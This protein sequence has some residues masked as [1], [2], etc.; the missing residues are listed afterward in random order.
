MIKIIK[1]NRG[2][3]YLIDKNTNEI[4]EKYDP[5]NTDIVL[6]VRLE[7]GSVLNVDS[8]QIHQQV[9]GSIYFDYFEDRYLI[10]DDYQDLLIRSGYIVID[11]YDK[12]FEMDR[13]KGIELRKNIIEKIKGKC[14]NDPIDY[15]VPLDINHGINETKIEF[16]KGGFRYTV[17]I[18]TINNIV[19]KNQ[20]RKMNQLPFYPF[21]KNMDKYGT[22]YLSMFCQKLEPVDSPNSRF[23][24]AEDFIS[25]LIKSLSEIDNQVHY[26]PLMIKKRI[27]HWIA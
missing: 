18:N 15:D 2:T 11:D 24:I 19:T 10:D 6:V 22:L 25:K 5:E 4:I 21:D 7:D 27:V 13:E 3:N 16:E 20:T 12:K 1:L 17:Y 14:N 26:V 8:S 9:G 23:E